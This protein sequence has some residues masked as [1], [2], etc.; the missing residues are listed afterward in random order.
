MV[1]HICPSHSVSYPSVVR[2]FCCHSLAAVSDSYGVRAVSE[3]ASSY[4]LFSQ[5]LQPRFK[6]NKKPIKN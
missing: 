6:K 4:L 5:V 1:L 3:P 2:S